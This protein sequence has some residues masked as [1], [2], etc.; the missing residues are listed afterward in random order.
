MT[1][2]T[3]ENFNKDKVI[4]GDIYSS[5]KPVPYQ[6]VPIQYKYSSSCT[7]DL[8]I[9]TPKLESYGVFQNRDMKTKVLNGYSLGL[10]FPSSDDNR[11]F[12]DLLLKVTDLI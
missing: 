3:L 11:E 8:V 4:L 1:F 12:Y 10:K 6:L 9:R 2:V 7:K 5:T